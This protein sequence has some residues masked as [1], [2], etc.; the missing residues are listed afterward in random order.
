M[1]KPTYHRPFPRYQLRQVCD[2]D[3]PQVYWRGY[4]PVGKLETSKKE[5]AVLL[6]RL[7]FSLAAGDM[8]SEH[9]IKPTP[10]QVI[11]FLSACQ[12]DP[13]IK[14]GVM[15]SM[16]QKKVVPELWEAFARFDWGTG[17]SPEEPI[18]VVEPKRLPLYA[19]VV[20]ATAGLNV[21]RVPTTVNNKPLYA[22]R[23]GD[24]VDLYHHMN[25]WAAI[26]PNWDKPTEAEWVYAT[27][28]KKM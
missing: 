8:Y 16:D 19:A 28:L 2:F 27:Y 18:V 10:Q 20:N 26:N 4:L 6:P 7:P 3:C 17:E 9:G 13:E 15:W 11:E 1:R 14:A 5:Y 22:R 25:G 24:C 21:R 23:F 12:K